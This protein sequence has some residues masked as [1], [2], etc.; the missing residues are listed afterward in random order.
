[1]NLSELRDSATEAILDIARPA[2]RKGAEEIISKESDLVAGDIVTDVDTNV[3]NAL[4]LVLPRLL[5]GSRFVG[6]E[7][8]QEIEDPAA[9]PTWILDPLDGTYNFARGFPCYGCALALLV[10]G[11]PVMAIVYDGVA[12]VM[13]DAIAGQG[14]R[15]NGRAL[16]F[17]TET[18]ASAPAA[19]SSGFLQFALEH[20][21]AMLLE[22][23]RAVSPRFRVFGSQAVQLCWAAS[24][25]LRFNVN[26]ETKLW[27]DAAGW[28]IATEAGAAH[29]LASGTPLFPLM[30]GSAAVKGES[31]FSMAGEPAAVEKVFEAVSGLI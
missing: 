23:V 1:M 16:R 7:D 2:F 13:F 12:E 21:E 17:N 31:L 24:G 19:I 8:F 10:D 9:Q 20:P 28:L 30:P 4:A 3:Q 14:A 26:R 5:P 6:E 25:K 15:E 22:A 29:K 11:A 18:A 27:D